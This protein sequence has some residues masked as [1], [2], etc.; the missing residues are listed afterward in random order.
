MPVAIPVMGRSVERVY[1]DFVADNLDY[2]TRSSLADRSIWVT[3][4]IK[5]AHRRRWVRLISFDLRADRVD[6]IDRSRGEPPQLQVH[7]N[8]A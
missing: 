7:S 3:V 5:L 8:A 4:Q 1:S 2:G 6:R